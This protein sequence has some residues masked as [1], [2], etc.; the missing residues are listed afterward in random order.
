VVVDE[1]PEG[2]P[3]V[4]LPSQPAVFAPSYAPEEIT[5]IAQRLRKAAG[6]PDEPL[7]EVA[8]AAG[9]MAKLKDKLTP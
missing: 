4:D 9:T 6:L 1:A 8:P 3:P 7:G 2:F 5:E